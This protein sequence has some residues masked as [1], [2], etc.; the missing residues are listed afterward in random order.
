MNKMISFDEMH[1][2]FKMSYPNKS[3]KDFETA[4]ETGLVHVWWNQ[5]CFENLVR[6]LLSFKYSEGSMKGVK[7]K[8]GDEVTDQDRW[9]IRKSLN[10]YLKMTKQ[11]E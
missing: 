6:A 3:D 8:S 11:K 5:P 2:L 1:K 10:N 4:V 9:Q 7:L